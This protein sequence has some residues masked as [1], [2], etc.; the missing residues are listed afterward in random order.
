MSSKVDESDRPVENVDRVL[1]GEGMTRF[2][3]DEVWYRRMMR[4]QA[5]LASAAFLL[6]LELPGYVKLLY[7]FNLGVGMILAGRNHFRRQYMNKYTAMV[8]NS[9]PVRLRVCVEFSLPLAFAH[10][11]CSYKP[12]TPLSPAK[13]TFDVRKTWTFFPPD[14][15]VSSR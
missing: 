2:T 6:H 11:L 13:K 9:V 4:D 7:R 5:I 15:H 1:E 12:F 10:L 8:H 14:T 3:F